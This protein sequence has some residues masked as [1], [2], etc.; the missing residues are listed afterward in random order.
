MMKNVKI[1][2]ETHRL[3]SIKAAKL[4]VHKNI[5][6]SALIELALSMTDEAILDAMFSVT[7]HVRKEYP[8][9]DQQP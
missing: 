5:L 8:S 7:S 6:A 1:D 4:G 3:M 2:A 9:Q